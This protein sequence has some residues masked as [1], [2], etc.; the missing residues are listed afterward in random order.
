MSEFEGERQGFTNRVLV[1]REMR[2][3]TEAGSGLYIISHAKPK[4]PSQRYQTDRSVASD[5]LH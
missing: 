2:R 1:I 4:L 3:N 5:L